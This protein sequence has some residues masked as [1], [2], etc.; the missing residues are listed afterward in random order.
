MKGSTSF[1]GDHPPIVAV[2]RIARFDRHGTIH[3]TTV[4]HLESGDRF[5]I[6]DT[7]DIVVRHADGRV[8]AHCPK[9]PRIV[10]RRL[11]PPRRVLP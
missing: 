5:S 6:S 7:G 9:R 4:F 2:D 3:A 8:E 10:V 1:P 11:P